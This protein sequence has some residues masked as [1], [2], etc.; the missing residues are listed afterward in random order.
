[1]RI[2]VTGSASCFG[3]ALLPMLCDNSRVKKV[4][5]IDIKKTCFKHPKMDTEILDIRSPSLSVRMKNYDAVIHLAFAVKREGRNDNE[6][7]DINVYGSQNVVQAAMQNGIK[8][9]INLSSVSVYGNGLNKTELDVLNPSSTFL[10]AQHK[11]E[12]EEYISS[13]FPSAIQLRSH[14]IFGKHSQQFLKNMFR[15]IVCVKFP[16]SEIPKQQVIHEDDLVKAVML[17]LHAPENI[18]GAFNLAAPEIIDLA[19]GY[20]RKGRTFVLPLS[21]SV[22]KYL[23]AFMKRVKPKDEYQWIEMVGTTLT[24]QCDR[25]KNI[26]GWIPE[27]SAWDARKDA[28][29]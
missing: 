9:F 29:L 14:L 16:R 25:A 2:F 7:M 24:V 8:K 6:M 11:A 22:V 5:G 28:L 18:S 3:A 13:H 23:T 1:M 21:Y 26:L 15:S 17:A 12:L 27:K 10:Y 20:V 4:T 19:G